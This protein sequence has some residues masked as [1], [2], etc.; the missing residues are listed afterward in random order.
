MNAAGTSTVRK[1]RSTDGWRKDDVRKAV[2]GALKGGM[3]VGRI[4]FTRR[5]FA[6][7]AGDDSNQGSE[8]DRCARLMEEAFGEGGDD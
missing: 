1:P 3:P 7:F 8:A 4:E 2:E 6:L 5:G